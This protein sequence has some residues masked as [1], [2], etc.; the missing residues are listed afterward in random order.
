MFGHFPES[1]A[2]GHVE[3]A[4]KDKQCD[5]K[6]SGFLL[7]C[8]FYCWANIIWYRISLWSVWVC[9]LAYVPA[10]HLT[11]PQ[12]PAYSWGYVGETAPIPCQRCSAGAKSVGFQCKAQP[13]GVCCGEKELQLS[14][15]QYNALCY[16][17]SPVFVRK[18]NNQNIG[19]HSSQIYNAKNSTGKTG[20]N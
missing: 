19:K 14:Q 15:T 2:L 18:W 4:L 13:C 12:P 3:I 20:C 7:F 11:H 9:Y 6:Y 8:S 10:Q 1:R 16:W 5:N 17:F